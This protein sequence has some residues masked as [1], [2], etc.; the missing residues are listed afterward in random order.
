MVKTNRFGNNKKEIKMERVI[1]NYLKEQIQ[2]MFDRYVNR[3]VEEGCVE[4]HPNYVPWGDTYANEGNYIEETDM[5]DIRD[6]F[7]N[8]MNCDI[9]MASDLLRD[10]DIDITPKNIKEVRN[11]TEEVL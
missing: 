9:E 1:K 8:E 10:N 7:V 4:T 3:C 5:E 6:S 2:D 11:L